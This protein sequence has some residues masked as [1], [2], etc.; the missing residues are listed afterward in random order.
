M[1]SRRAILVSLLMAPAASLLSATEVSV[2]SEV[3][4]T[5]LKDKTR[6]LIQKLTATLEYAYLNAA[7]NPNDARA[8][9]CVHDYTHAVLLDMKTKNELADFILVC[10]ASNNPPL[11]LSEVPVVD[12]AIRTINETHEIRI[13]SEQNRSR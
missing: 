10:D 13:H 6:Q 4:S 5:V 2:N 8:Q 12:I 11:V 9:K 7:W 3:S 1:V